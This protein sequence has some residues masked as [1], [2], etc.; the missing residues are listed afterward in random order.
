[1]TSNRQISREDYEALYGVLDEYVSAG[2]SADLIGERLSKGGKQ[3]SSLNFG[4]PVS[5]K[6]FVFQPLSAGV[7]DYQRQQFRNAIQHLLR[8]K[9]PYQLEVPTL[10]PTLMALRSKEALSAEAMAE[11][12]VAGM[13]WQ[14]STGSINA[15][16][17]SISFNTPPPS[18]TIKA[19]E[20][21]KAVVEEMEQTPVPQSNSRMRMAMRYGLPTLGALLGVYGLASLTGQPPK[22]SSTARARVDGEAAV[23]A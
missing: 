17:L 14:P 12:G 1:M 5:G 9:E 15:E 23:K 11:A 13:G 3:W 18:N 19:V 22:E 16:Q 2:R 21:Q 7:Q 6:A 10:Q 20:H 8:T 4:S